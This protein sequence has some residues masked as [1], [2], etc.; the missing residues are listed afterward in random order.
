MTA[1]DILASAYAEAGVPLDQL[2]YSQNMRRLLIA[3]QR[4]GLRDTTRRKAWREMLKLR[5]RGALPRVG[6][7]KRS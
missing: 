6:R 7:H 3:A 1:A 4:L 5:K 2:P